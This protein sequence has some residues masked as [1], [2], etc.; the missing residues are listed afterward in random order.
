MI[1]VVV[2]GQETKAFEVHI[3]SDLNL[4]M[5]YKYFL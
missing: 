1:V 2:K 4:N 5:V 3:E